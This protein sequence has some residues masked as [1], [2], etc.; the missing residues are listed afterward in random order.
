[1]KKFL[2]VLLSIFLTIALF[3]TLL[4]GVVKE[5]AKP[6][7][8]KDLVM[9]AGKSVSVMEKNDGLYYPG[10][11]ILR[12]TQFD[13]GFDFSSFDLSSI[14]FTNLDIP[15]LIKEYATEFDY[16]IDEE[17]IEEVLS[18]PETSKLL[19]KYSYEIIDYM[20]GTSDSLT[21]D[22]A[23][24]TSLVNKTIDK[25]EEKTGEVIDRTGLDEMIT[26]NISA[27]SEEIVSALDEVK[28]ENSEVIK[29]LKLVMDILSTKTFVICVLV[30]I[31][32]ALLILIVNL[33]IFTTLKYL[34]ISS[35]I[36]GILVVMVVVVANGSL[37]FATNLI[38]K[39]FE[40]SQGLL[41]FAAGIIISIL[42][43]LMINGIV[44]AVAGLILLIV[45]I[46]F[47]NKKPV[48]VKTSASDETIAVEKE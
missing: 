5:V 18:D 12:T 10:Q 6:S 42:K 16:E 9:Q 45:S 28:N 47:G 11:K 31:C 14:D 26:E 41:D 27:A 1:M 36:A 3:I 44:S 13:E 29:D 48:A 22:S 46:I 30:C 23:E 24:I 32:F 40:L 38:M 17:L 35:L 15:S 4:L 25:Y 37:S 34:S 8:I 33:N 21:I 20:T 43:K 2:S 19:D 39:E 7:V